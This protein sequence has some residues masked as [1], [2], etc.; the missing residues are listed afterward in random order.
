MTDAVLTDDAPDGGKYGYYAT[1]P[2]QEFDHVILQAD[3]AL[4]AYLSFYRFRRLGGI[5]RADKR[6]KR[7][8]ADGRKP[9]LKHLEPLDSLN[10]GIHFVSDHPPVRIFSLSV[11]ALLV[12]FESA[13]NAYFFSLNN[14]LGL[15]GGLFQ[16]AA[17][18][19]SNV[20]VAYF[21]VGFW[22]LRH[23]TVPWQY[24][25][26]KKVFGVIAIVTGLI[27]IVLVNLSAAHFRNIQD[28]SVENIEP[29]S[30]AELTSTW[31]FIPGM[32][33]DCEVILA[34]E[35]GASLA[36]A[37]ANAMCR[38]FNL[39]SLD[40]VVLF[41]L[42]IAI[43]AVAA[44]EGRRSDSAFPGLSDAA[45]KVERSRDD[46][47]EALEEYRD[48][49]DD[50]VEQIKQ[51]LGEKVS[52]DDRIALY[53]ALDARIEPYRKL[54]ETSAIQLVDEFDVPPWVLQEL[55]APGS[56]DPRLNPD[57]DEE[58]DNR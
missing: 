3:Y 27:M 7:D 55:G 56:D 5:D 54:F 28:M 13:A 40:A 10:R 47:L 43:A 22:G 57:E 32:A 44:F 41:A 17:V 33:A 20:A 12:L 34:G 48:S 35:L 4:R 31:T 49:Y 58:E 36:G 37:A 24:H 9:S 16:A 23:I 52:A 11:I 18:S 30:P 51:D 6:M 45:R 15:L 14:P 26:P 25:W 39:Y 19:L 50:I 42:G 29:P 21:I 2:S 46:L 1:R 38:P 8:R 53:R